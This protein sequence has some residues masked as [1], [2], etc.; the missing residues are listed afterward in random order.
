MGG[1][2]NAQE[3]DALILEMPE[4][5]QTGLEFLRLPKFRS[6]LNSPYTK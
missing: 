1:Q 6:A 2:E 4:D 3:E 5:E